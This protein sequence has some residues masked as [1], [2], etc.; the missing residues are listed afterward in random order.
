M[1]VGAWLIVVGI[2]VIGWC[3]VLLPRQLRKIREGTTIRGGQRYDAHFTR[4]AVR[5][6]LSSAPVIGY[7]AVVIGAVYMLT[8][9]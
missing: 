9:L 7:L 4:P 5:R 3:Q 1:P 8:E 2:V 6:L